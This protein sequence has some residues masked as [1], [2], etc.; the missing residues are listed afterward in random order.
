MNWIFFLFLVT[1]GITSQSKVKVKHLKPNQVHK[2]VA[3]KKSL[4][5]FPKTTKKKD[6]SSLKTVNTKFNLDKDCFN[7]E[8]LDNIDELNEDQIK[9]LKDSE[10]LQTISITEIDI[11]NKFVSDHIKEQEAVDI[12]NSIKPSNGD[13]L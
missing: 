10:L 4:A 13:K 1:N 7:E 11:E 6:N 9:L 5:I 12:H 2:M 3:C 8:L